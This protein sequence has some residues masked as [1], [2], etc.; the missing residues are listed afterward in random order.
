MKVKFHQRHALI[1]PRNER[2]LKS[3]LLVRRKSKEDLLLSNEFKIPSQSNAN[4]YSND[5]I[6][7]CFSRKDVLAL[8]PNGGILPSTP[9]ACTK[10]K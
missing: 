5:T 7:N 4:T 9:M 10:N 8:L 3:V 6:I 2:L 1:N